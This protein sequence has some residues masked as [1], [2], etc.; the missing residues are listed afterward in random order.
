[1]DMRG[2]VVALVGL[3][4]CAQLFG[5][6]N[7]SGPTGTATLQ[8][9]RKSVGATVVSNPL[10]ISTLTATFVVPNAAN[11]MAPTLVPG[12]MAAM[13]TWTA[14]VGSAQPSVEFTLPDLPMPYEHLWALPSQMVRGHFVAFEHPG[15]QPAPSAT[16][17]MVSVM[18]PGAYAGEAIDIDVIGAWMGYSLSG[19]D[20]PGA[21]ATMVT[22]SI[23]YS[24]FTPLT[25]SP[26]AKIAN[27]DAVL[28]MRHTGT[29]LTGVFSTSFDQNDT[30]DTI[31]GTMMNVTPNQMLAASISTNNFTTR[32]ATVRPTVSGLSMA[33][34]VTAAPGYAIGATI[35]P[36]LQ[37]GTQKAGDTMVTGTYGNPFSSRGW[38][39][40]LQFYAASGRTAM[41]GG[42]TAQLGAQITTVVDPSMVS[43][44]D[45]PAPLAEMVTLDSNQLNVDNK[46]VTLDPTA[47]HVV[48]V[49]TETLPAAQLYLLEI[50]ELVVTG[51]SVARKPV[52]DAIG[53]QSSFTLPPNVFQTNHVYVITA[54]TTTGGFPNAAVGD[55]ETTSLP[56]TT[57]VVDSGVFTVTP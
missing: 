34:Q 30:M 54:G 2:L 28:V 48:N 39:E 52:L 53:M 38:H 32:F 25:L 23:P 18:L 46:M 6:D 37:S 22:A 11:P 42:A 24:K 40:V 5:I 14:N 56:F 49:I 9:N 51:T 4:G 29:T 27:A 47:A 17:E 7:T 35:G 13:D 50:S 33:W 15:M 20:L 16:T 36:S 45:L 3:S 8:L 55:I 31:S 26:A 43:V 57:A 41:L 1:M 10:D 12:T 19:A 44:L 21:G